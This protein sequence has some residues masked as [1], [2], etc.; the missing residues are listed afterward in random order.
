MNRAQ[1]ERAV[2]KMLMSGYGHYSREEEHKVLM[3]L[4]QGNQL[5]FDGNDSDDIKLADKAITEFPLA[6]QPLRA[7]KN[8][9]IC[10]V[11]IICRY[12][13]DLG[14]DDAK[15]YALSDYYINEIEACADMNNWSA[16]LEEITRHY[17]DL[18][19][20]GREKRYS[21]QVSRAIRYINQH[22]YGVCRLQD[23]AKEIKLHSGYLSSLFKAETGVSF[24]EYI[25]NIKMDEARNLLLNGE[26]SISEIAEMLG[27]QSLSYFSKV[28]RQV[29]GCSPREY[30]VGANPERIWCEEGC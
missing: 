22:L 28:F 4:L 7:L 9:L 1:A 3:A 23:V 27:Y 13:A 2:K 25:R 19:R 24:T 12:A 18:V 10:F 5:L 14:A 16:I 11:A 15:C 30:A 17:K 8:S 6:A 21:M 29:Y 26:Y 20:T